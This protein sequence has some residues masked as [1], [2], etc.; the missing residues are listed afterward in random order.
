MGFS[1]YKNAEPGLDI[2][3]PNGRLFAYRFEKV[4]TLEMV[5]SQDSPLVQ[6]A[7][8]LVAALYSYGRCA[9]KGQAPPE[10]LLTPLHL[11]I[12]AAILPAYVQIPTFGHLM[13]SPTFLVN[14][15]RHLPGFKLK[16]DAIVK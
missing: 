11:I 9:A 13:G 6:A 1:L 8:L 7:D 3:L 16:A 2:Y 4:Q 15:F 14:M 10:W 12:A 5:R